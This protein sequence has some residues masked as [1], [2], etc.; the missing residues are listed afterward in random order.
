MM[1]ATLKI[2]PE[3]RNKRSGRTEKVRIREI[4]DRT[5]RTWLSDAVE[6]AAADGV[7]FS[8]DTAHV[9]SQLCH[10]HAVCGYSAEGVAEFNGTQEHQ[11]DEGVYEGVCARCCGTS[12]CALPDVRDGRR[13]YVESTRLRVNQPIFLV[14]R[15]L[16]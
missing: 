10:A 16:E 2:P 7:T 3:R 15:Q 12:P 13:G 4:T 11:L 6:A 9:P 8:V 5:V 1:V 14:F